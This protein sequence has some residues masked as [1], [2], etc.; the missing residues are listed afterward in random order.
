MRIH[1][2]HGIKMLQYRQCLRLGAQT[3]IK[4]MMHNTLK[5]IK[6]QAREFIQRIFSRK[7]SPVSAAILGLE[8]ELNTIKNLLFLRLEL[9]YLYEPRISSHQIFTFKCMPTD[10]PST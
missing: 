5:R 9:L 3:R 2:S 7:K 1:I 10:A 4:T 8:K 6:A